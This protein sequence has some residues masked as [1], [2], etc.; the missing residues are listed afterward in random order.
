MAFHFIKLITSS[1]QQ[2]RKTL[3]EVD[4]MDEMTRQEALEKADAMAAHIAYPSEMLDNDKLTEFY[5]GV[6]I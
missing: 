2:F 5:A 6:W 4:W 1:R 3:T